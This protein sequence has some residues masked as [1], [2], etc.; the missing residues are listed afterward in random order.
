MVRTVKVA[1]ALIFVKE[2]G[3]AS[4]TLVNVVCNN[5]KELQTALNK[6]FGRGNTFVQAVKWCERVYEMD[7]TFFFANAKMIKD[8]STEAST[9]ASIEA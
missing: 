4:Q 8:T 9:E 5:E 1:K 2:N 7:D 3:K 6:Q